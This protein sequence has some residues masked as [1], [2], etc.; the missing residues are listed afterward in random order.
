MMMMITEGLKELL[1]YGLGILEVRCS[2]K[3]TA[4]QRYAGVNP[5]DFL[6]LA[7]YGQPSQSSKPSYT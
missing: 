7:A 5:S 3:Q 6:A 4:L 1:I 2:E